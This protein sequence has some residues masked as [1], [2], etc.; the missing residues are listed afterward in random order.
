MQNKFYYKNEFILKFWNIYIYIYILFI[1]KIFEQ[2]EKEKNETPRPLARTQSVCSLLS[3]FVTYRWAAILSFTSLPSVL[4]QEW[5]V[6]AC[7]APARL[8]LLI[9]HLLAVRR[10]RSC[11]GPV[12][13]FESRAK[14]KKLDPLRKCVSVYIYTLSSKYI[15]KILNNKSL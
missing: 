3:F 9:G 14:Q 13:R 4:L 8:L 10:R 1:K 2:K 6:P 5:H 7:F 15:N 12:L 11:A